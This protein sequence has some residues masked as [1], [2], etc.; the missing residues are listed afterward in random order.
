[1]IQ[2]LK[3]GTFFSKNNYSGKS[4]ALTSDAGTPVIADPGSSL[5]QACISNRFILHVL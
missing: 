4:V 2:L 3:T 5:V 1:M